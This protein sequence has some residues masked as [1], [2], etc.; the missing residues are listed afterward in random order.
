M[1]CL[2]QLQRW[3]RRHGQQLHEVK[4]WLIIMK[5]LMAKIVGGSVHPCTYSCFEHSTVLTLAFPKLFINAQPAACHSRC[6]CCCWVA[7]ASL[8]PSLLQLMPPRCLLQMLLVAF[9][10]GPRSSL[11]CAPAV[12]HAGY[13]S[14]AHAPRF[15]RSTSS[16]TP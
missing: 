12:K 5:R 13:A 11:C 1:I 4:I 6:C 14:T 15:H 3:R 9:L 7:S 16:S 8:M 2:R 10:L